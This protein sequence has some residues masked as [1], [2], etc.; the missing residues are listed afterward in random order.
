VKSP[1]Q[2]RLSGGE[3]TANGRSR[4]LF[5]RVSRGLTLAMLGL[6]VLL[7]VA[8]GSRHQQS[9]ARFARLEALLDE[10]L[11]PGTTYARVTFFLDAQGYKYSTEEGGR[12][13]VAVIQRVDQQT[14]T[15][16]TARV[17]FQFDASGQLVSC[18]VTPWPF[19]P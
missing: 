10:Q 13:V 1:A 8:C 3:A 18:E 19:A 16:V 6:S 4:P 5:V 2:V 15:R 14:L 17:E 7:P 12:R 9:D 11:P